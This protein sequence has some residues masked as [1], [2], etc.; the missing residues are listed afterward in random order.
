LDVDFFYFLKRFLLRCFLR[1]SVLQKLA[2]S[3]FWTWVI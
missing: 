2:L 3:F 1:L